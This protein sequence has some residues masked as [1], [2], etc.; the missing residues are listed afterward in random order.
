MLKKQEILKKVWH[1]YFKYL[2]LPKIFRTL[3][4][5]F[6]KLRFSFEFLS[7]VLCIG[8]SKLKILTV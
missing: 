6:V 8:I 3:Y 5:Y 7:D 1:I 2:E 4:N